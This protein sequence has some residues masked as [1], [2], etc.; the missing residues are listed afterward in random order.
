MVTI[1]PRLAMAGI[2]NPAFSARAGV[3]IA[4]GHGDDRGGDR[5]KVG[6]DTCDPGPADLNVRHRRSSHDPCPVSPRRGRLRE[7]QPEAVHTAVGRAEGRPDHV[8]SQ[9]GEHLPGLPGVERLDPQAGNLALGLGHPARLLHLVL[10]LGHD[11]HVSATLI[12]DVGPQFL[13]QAP[14]ELC[15]SKVQFRVVGWRAL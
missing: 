8:G 13:R 15:A 9:C 6:D 7:G 3:W 10:R 1:W 11:A 4:C 12:S 14:V 2:R 5:P